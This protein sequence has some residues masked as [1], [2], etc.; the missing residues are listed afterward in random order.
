[1]VQASLSKRLG[2]L[3]R[4]HGEWDLLLLAL[5]IR[6]AFAMLLDPQPISDAAWYWQAAL[7]LA[8]GE[9]YVV[10][11]L[12]TAYFPVGYPALL[13]AILR[14]GAMHA[15]AGRL[16]QV[17]CSVAIVWLG[18][19]LARRFT[20]DRQSGRRA[21]LVLAL[22]PVQWIYCAV[23]LSEPLF[24]ALLLGIVALLWTRDAR[25]PWP[26][27]ALAGLLTGAACLV[28]PQAAVVPAIALLADISWNREELSR[29][30]LRLAVVAGLAAAILTPWALRNR[31]VFGQAVAV[32][33]NGGINLWI[34]NN[35]EANGRYVATPAVLDVLH[36]GADEA[37]R[38]H[39]AG[40]QARAWIAAHPGQALALL[41][42]KLLNFYVPDQLAADLI[43]QGQPSLGMGWRWFTGLAWLTDL[44]CLLLVPA[45]LLAWLHAGRPPVV[46][47]GLA[48]ALALHGIYLVFF[49]ASRFHFPLVPW[50][51]IQAVACWPKRI[52]A[53]D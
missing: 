52:P 40:Q 5:A 53:I 26:R 39:H 41:P 22:L 24:T 27:I 33:T 35:P 25:V 15:L 14:V 28:K 20:G 16:L 17:A 11:G 9:G 10:A 13:A 46:R 45:W 31:T 38:D 1:M 4:P 3:D 12:P 7:H 21:M 18:G 43:A 8:Q 32:S 37:A 42:R 50:L 23:L 19:H 34:G 51:V 29:A 47:T 49:G 36:Q 2:W 30:G 6:L 44:L 48:V